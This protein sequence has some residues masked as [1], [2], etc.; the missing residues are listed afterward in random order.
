MNTRD[1]STDA[2]T[3][4][5]LL[6]WTA[7]YFTRRDL[8]SPRL[9]AELLLA[10]VLGCERLR[11]YT[12]PDRPAAADE[13]A[14]L[15]SLVERAGRHEPIQYLLGEAWFFGRPFMVTPDTLIPRPSSETIIEEALQHFRSQSRL[16]D[17]L[18]IIDI[19]T[20]SG[21]LAISLAAALPEAS[22]IATDISAVA[23]EVAQRNAARH[24]VAD[25]IDF[26]TGS[27]FEPLAH[28][29]PP[30]RA[31]LLTSNPPYISD[32]EWA[33]V[34]RNVRDYEPTTALRAGPD[35]LNLLRPL[36]AGAHTH[37]RPGGRILLEIAASQAAAVEA[38][39]ARNQAL[40]AVRI[41]KDHESLPRV[42]AAEVA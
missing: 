13:L 6:A 33:Q 23:L 25:R 31:D 18:T 28:R 34:A 37:V 2:W 20:G 16:N 12:D 5:R 21:I 38:L 30:V 35:G 1:T 29:G 14:R 36:I 4:R 39:A 27:L 7:D 19:G 11:L 26:A 41:L 15:R 3:T 17:P 22:V 10:C 40:A 24:G 32:A 9:S 8:D 42:L